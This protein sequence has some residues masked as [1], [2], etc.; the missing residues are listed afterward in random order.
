MSQ[1]QGTDESTPSPVS[2]GKQQE[3]QP[4]HHDHTSTQG[5]EKPQGISAEEEHFDRRNDAPDVSQALGEI[6]RSIC[7]LQSTLHGGQLEAIT[8]YQRAPFAV[9]T[10]IA[11]DIADS[12]D[13]LRAIGARH[14]GAR[15]GQ[16]DL[17]YRGPNTAFVLQRENAVLGSPPQAARWTPAVSP[18]GSSA[19]A[20]PPSAFQVLGAYGPQAEG[21]LDSGGNTQPNTNPSHIFPYVQ[22]RTAFPPTPELYRSQRVQTP[23]V[24]PLMSAPFFHQQQQ[25]Q[26]RQP[27]AVPGH[28]D[29]RSLSAV[30][31][32]AVVLQPP[33]PNTTPNHLHQGI[34]LRGEEGQRG[35]QE[36]QQ[37]PAFPSPGGGVTM[38]IPLHYDTPAGTRVALYRSHLPDHPFNSHPT[39]PGLR[40]ATTTTA[41]TTAGAVMQEL[42]AGTPPPSRAPMSP[43]DHRSGACPPA[44]SARVDSGSDDGLDSP[45]VELRWGYVFE[46]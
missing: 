16:P 30:S 15:P 7:Q 24:S 17:Q 32:P 40:E 8:P 27:L 41:T 43:G 1:C 14:A 21:V 11:D 36:Q 26:H 20:A 37:Q 39:G 3:K 6:Q 34:L 38:S 4:Q 9:L 5:S 10:N 25:Q 23:P 45:E 12:L 35:G 42:A 22:S 18:L 13:W 33:T 46:E 29:I 31:D 2:S 44:T 28:S 19:G